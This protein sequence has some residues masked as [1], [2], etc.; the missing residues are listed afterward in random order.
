MIRP[1]DPAAGA[2]II[3]GVTAPFARPL[4]VAIFLAPLLVAGCTKPIPP[5]AAT[6]VVVPD[7]DL[8]A[9][10]NASLDV[11]NRYEFTP[12]RQDRAAG[13][14]VSVPLSS[15]QFWEAWRFDTI[16]TYENAQASLQTI[17]RKVT[18]RFVRAAAGSRWQVDV[19]V[20]VFRLQLPERQVTATSSGLELYSSKLPTAEGEVVDRSRSAYLEPLGRDERVESRLLE[21]ILDQAG[22]GDVEYIE[23]APG[24]QTP[25]QSPPVAPAETPA[26]GE[27]AEIR[28]EPL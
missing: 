19:Q 27:P 16:G 22:V 24:E 23:A 1:V 20:D 21:Q 11:L 4:V 13:V 25:A 15:K 2:R 14:I 3:R 6:G 12:D 9:L 17:F 26:N 7:A 10:W 5:D 8:D 28:P 18:V